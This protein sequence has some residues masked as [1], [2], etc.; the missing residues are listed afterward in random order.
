MSDGLRFLSAEASFFIPHARHAEGILGLW[1]CNFIFAVSTVTI[2][3]SLQI[4]R[5]IL[6]H[7]PLSQEVVCPP[8]IHLSTI[9][10]AQ[11][12]QVRKQLI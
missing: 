1:N 7:F 12:K 8:P 10:Y 9:P 2:S 5:F 3:G 6:G 11:L 4:V